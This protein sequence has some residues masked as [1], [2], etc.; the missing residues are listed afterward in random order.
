MANNNTK[1]AHNNGFSGLVAQKKGTKDWG[2]KTGRRVN[3][4]KERA[5]RGKKPWVGA[6]KAKFK[7]GGEES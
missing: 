4:S 7:F 2:Q 1:S 5:A 6:S 3:S